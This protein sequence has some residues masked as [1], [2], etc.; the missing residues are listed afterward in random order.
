MSPYAIFVIVLTI[1]YIIYYGYNISKD[2]YGKKNVEESSEEV[3]DGFENDVVATPV[4]ETGDGF[5]LGED[6]EVSAPA[7]ADAQATEPAASAIQEKL[8]GVTSQMQEADIASDGG[9]D[10]FDLAEMMVECASGSSRRRTL[11]I[12]SDNV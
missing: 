7:F 8:S 3:F 2:V 12:V 9:I 4:T 1:A 10:Q 6:A 11:N 5:S